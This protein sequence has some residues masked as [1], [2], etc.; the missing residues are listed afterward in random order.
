MAISL[1]LNQKK[2][3]ENETQNLSI[4]VCFDNNV[5]TNRYQRQR[6]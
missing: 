2:N 5:A 1:D 4:D 3:G 6:G